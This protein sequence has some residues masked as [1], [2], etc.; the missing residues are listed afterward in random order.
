M[1]RKT[2][3]LLIRAGLNLQAS[4]LV[5]FYNERAVERA[6]TTFA[7]LSFGSPRRFAVRLF[8]ATANTIFGIRLSL[9]PPKGC[10]LNT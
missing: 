3:M 7:P 5:D 2:G 1:L 4:F 6:A 8:E 10:T 9:T